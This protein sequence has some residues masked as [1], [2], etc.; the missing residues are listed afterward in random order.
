[1]VELALVDLA[2]G[3]FVPLFEEV[4]DTV[5]RP[6]KRILE[7][8]LQVLGHIDLAAIVTIK[9]LE[10]LFEL[11][12]GELAFLP[13]PHQRAE[14][15]EVK[16]AVLVTICSIAFHGILAHAGDKV[17]LPGALFIVLGGSF[18][19]HLRSLSSVRLCCPLAASLTSRERRPSRSNSV[20]GAARHTSASFNGGRGSL[21][22]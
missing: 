21:T 8:E 14:L 22:D 1:M 16:L 10:A 12:I 20:G 2:G 9:L 18:F 5:R 11:I 4:H 15:A 17:F 7:R 19:C 6:C 3:V 13:R